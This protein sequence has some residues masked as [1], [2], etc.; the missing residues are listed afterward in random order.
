MATWL[1]LDGD[2]M[3]HRSY[4]A[5]G[6]LSDNGELTGVVYGFLRDTLR[7]IEKHYTRNVAFAFDLGD[8][9]RKQLFPEYKAKR[10]ALT[11]AEQGEKSELRRQMRLLRKEYL[12][13]VGWTNIFA[14]KGY[15]ADD[16]IASLCRAL[17][18]G[19][20]AI[21]VSRDADL[22]QLLNDRVVMWDPHAQR[23]VTPRSFNM[24][25]NIMPS[26]WVRV[27][28]I[29]GCRTDEIPGVKG[30]GPATAIKYLRGG[31]VSGPLR[32]S[33]DRHCQ[34]EAMVRNLKLVTLPYPGTEEF[35][36]QEDGFDSRRWD[37]LAD[38]IGMPSLKEHL[39]ADLRN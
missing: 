14:Q 27:K 9:V 23:M 25:W 4:H 38:R 29:A 17:P 35:T 3:A 6:K 15:E 32:D 8:S 19:D 7:L 5:L 34:S 28:A 10:Q 12:P 36:F 2:Y 39:P 24:T 1:I 37:A 31:N 22:F 11:Q 20:D 16:V 21:I 26:Q 33:I 30:V 18:E 13:E